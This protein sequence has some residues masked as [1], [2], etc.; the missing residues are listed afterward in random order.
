MKKAYTQLKEYVIKG[1]SEN[2]S[3]H[4]VYPFFQKIFSNDN[5]KRESE[6]AGCDIY[7]VGRLAVELKTHEAEW[8]QGFF[9]ALHYNKKG[10]SFSAVSVIANNF[11]GLWRLA[12]LSSEVTSI[13]LNTD[14]NKS[15]NEVG[16]INANKCNKA[17]KQKI[18]ESAYFLYN[19]E[20]PLFIDAKLYEFE[21]N[22]QHLD[23]MR[24]Q[25]NPNNFLRKIGL[26]KEYFED[27]LNA[28]HCFYTMLPFWDTTS[29]VPEARMPEQNVLWLN[30]QNGSSSSD[31]IIIEP[32]FQ[33]N[34][35][36]YVESQYVY[37]NNDEGISVDYY[38]SRLD[39]AFAEHD[40]AYIKQHGIFFTDINLSRFALWFIREKYG[41]K[42]LSEKHIVVDPAGGSGNLVSSWRRNHLKFKIVSEL[43]PE[44]L[45]TIELRLR[46]DP[47]QIQQGYS[48]IPKIYENKGLNFI[49]K[50]ASCYYDIIESYVKAEGK[51]IDKPFAFLLNPPYKNIDENE[52]DRE[53]THSNYTIDPSIIKITGNDAG[54]ER[55][56]AFLAQILELCKLQ[57]EKMPNVEPVVMIFTPTSWLIPRPT[58]ENFRKIFDKHF[59]FEKGFMITGQE[60]FKIPGRWPVAF[61]IWR[62][63]QGNNTNTIKLLDLTNLLKEMLSTIPWNEKV[64]TLNTEVNKII[65]GKGEVLFS[66]SRGEIRD[67][68][69]LMKNTRNERNER[70]QR[71]DFQ[72]NPTT[73]EVRSGD[74]FG[75]LPLN[76]ER[77]NNK[78]TYGW[79]DGLFIGFMDNGTPVRVKQDKYNRM[80]TRPDRI[81]FYL[82]NRMI[83][84]NMQKILCGPADHYGIC[85]CSIETAKVTLSW[86]AISKVINGRY[87][88]WANMFNIWSPKVIKKFEDDYYSLC[89]SFALSE[90]R[91]IVTKFEKDNPIKGAPEVFVDNPLCPA[92]PDSFWSTTL[93]SEVR[94]PLAKSLVDEIKSLYDYWNSD[95]CKGQFLN[96]VGLHDEPY[97]RYF[98]Y[99]DFVTPYSGLIQIKK[100]AEVNGKTAIL[101]RFEVIKELTKQVKEA[102]YDLLVNK[103]EYFK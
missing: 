49:D 16:K 92:N 94:N 86:F 23:V 72:R 82:D 31:K 18:L 87:P 8:L 68:L 25:I 81:W 99:P 61:T 6:A 77:R 38:F 70:Q 58:Y 66:N 50:S 41:E 32:R 100:Y 15:A 69:P 39:E 21:E 13:I 47:V 24:N 1:G 90:N 63:N 20:Q 67:L 103:F 28:I 80:S 62:Y 76:D 56:L 40:L 65:Q 34:F 102:I 46:H 33:K 26:L 95:Y 12:D 42:K 89:L 9:Q 83:K 35:R 30:G 36:K 43:N 53:A 101:S 2:A 27:P 11:I 57:K 5:F 45:K 44:L 85:A 52:L 98:N 73:S 37:T 19:K 10:L 54:N 29:K 59:K 79:H 14:A 71:Y 48:I 60:F 88:I 97:F 51:N 3:S 84:I 78:K 93:D 7:I 55:Y 74:V 91:C 17:L 96:N 22:L 4:H 64:E 75:G